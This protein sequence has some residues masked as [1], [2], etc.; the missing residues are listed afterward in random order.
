ML[1]RSG[2]G[3]SGVSL[4][5]YGYPP[6]QLPGI[7]P[8]AHSDLAVTP[9]HLPGCVF[10]RAAGLFLILRKRL[11][12]SD[13]IESRMRVMCRQFALF[14]SGTGFSANSGDGALGIIVR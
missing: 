6:K 2:R 1:C 10:L 11:H 4:R 12:G 14:I 5:Y 8:V 13:V 7:L 3:F 9:L